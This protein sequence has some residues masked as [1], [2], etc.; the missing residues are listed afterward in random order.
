MQVKSE[1]ALIKHLTFL[2]GVN[3]RV[4]IG[5]RRLT[6]LQQG[7]KNVLFSAEFDKWTARCFLVIAGNSIVGGIFCFS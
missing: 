5:P 7:Q 3:Y 4:L 6:K 1:I 2:G